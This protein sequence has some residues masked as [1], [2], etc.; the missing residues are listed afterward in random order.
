MAPPASKKRRQNG[1]T[2]GSS[3]TKPTLSHVLNIYPICD[4]LSSILPIADLIRLTRTCKQFSSLYQRALPAHWNI[5][6]RL[7]RFVN[8]PQSF[9]S[10]M[11]DRDALISGS[12]ALQFFE[13]VTW[14]ESD[15]DIFLEGQNEVSG[16][17]QYL[18]ERE[19]Y[20]FDHLSE[21]GSEVYSNM[22]KLFEVRTLVRTRDDSTKAQIQIIHTVDTPLLT[23]LKSFYTTVVVNIISWNKAYS[24]FPQPS[25]LYH[26]TFLLRR[27][28]DYFG[29]LLSKYG[30]RGWM[31]QGTLWPEEEASNKSMVG[32]R[33]IGDKWT[34]IIPLDQSG[35]SSPDKP[36]SVLDFSTFELFKSE[37]VSPNPGYYTMEAILFKSLVLEYDY[38]SSVNF[39][40]PGAF[41]TQ[42]AAPRLERLSMIE[43]CKIP[44][45][46]RPTRIQDAIDQVW[47]RADETDPD[48]PVRLY[49][50]NFDIGDIELPSYDHEIP[51]WY[52]EWERLRTS[53]VG[54]DDRESTM[55]D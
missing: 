12:F 3:L 10:E 34:W 55:Q 13:R 24:V 36:D 52:A 14:N 29:N 26:K 28:T 5:D 2:G 15:L 51:G 42:F 48:D 11:A 38:V 46:S 31:V 49:N 23:I 43:L 41:W 8:D 50:L 25:F 27:M 22:S 20:R 32:P 44:S 40:K 35:I 53:R 39:D 37:F 18:C 9:R 21:R 1:T 45:A 47:N 16:F 33:R 4:H 54:N 30:K 6:K 7:K 19:G 17:E